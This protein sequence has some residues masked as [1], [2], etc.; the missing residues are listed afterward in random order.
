M[1]KHVILRVKDGDRPDVELCLKEEKEKK[2]A[3]IEL[4]EHCWKQNPSD[5]PDFNGM[6]RFA[7]ERRM[8]IDSL[9]YWA[10]ILMF[11]Y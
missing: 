3:V 8:C 4:M 9:S 2:T 6:S 1:D 7:T 10:K 11:S 5:R